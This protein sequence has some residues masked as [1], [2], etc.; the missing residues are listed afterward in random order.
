MSRGLPVKH[1]ARRV[2]HQG[3]CLH[4]IGWAAGRDNDRVFGSAVRVFQVTGKVVCL[5]V[6]VVHGRREVFPSTGKVVCRSS[7]VVCHS[8]KVFRHKFKVFQGGHEVVRDGFEVFCDRF[9]VFRHRFEVFCR[10][11]PQSCRGIPIVYN[12]LSIFGS[13]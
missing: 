13:F 9:E 5:G 6:G 4:F 1:D 8:L 3:Q 2:P 12:R 11:L 7:K 10:R